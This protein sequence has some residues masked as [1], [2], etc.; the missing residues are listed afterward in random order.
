MPNV[1][2]LTEKVFVISIPHQHGSEL[3]TSMGKLNANNIDEALNKAELWIARKKREQK[4]KSYG[5]HCSV[6]IR[7]AYTGLKSTVLACSAEDI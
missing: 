7:E 2:D 6:D 4:C 3:G 1:C 5:N